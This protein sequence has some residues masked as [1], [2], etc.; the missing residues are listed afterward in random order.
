VLAP[1]LRPEI[2]PAAVALGLLVASQA[3][4]LA[5][6]F[7][8]KYAIDSGISRGRSGPLD[9]AAIAMLAAAVGVV[10]MKRSSILLAGRA[11]Q[12]ALRRLRERVFRHATSLDLSF[13]ERER[14]GVIVSRLTADLQAVEMLVVDTMVWAGSLVVYLLGSV[15]VLLV[16][17]VPMGTLSLL[18]IGPL[19]FALSAWFRTRSEKAYTRIRRATASVLTVMQ[20]SLRGFDVIQLFARQRR[21]VSDFARRNGEWRDA[22]G[23][24]IRLS[25]VYFPW[26]DIVR[27]AATLLVLG[28]GGWR[29]FQGVITVGLLAAFMLHLQ[30]T[31]EPIQALS[32]IYDQFQAAMAGLSRVAELL[33]ETANVVDAPGASGLDEA[34]GDL[35]LHTVAFRY[36]PDAP[37]AL[38]DVDLRAHAGR[39]IALVGETGA[40][41]STI[42]KL[43]LRF[44]D[45]TS[46][47]VSLDGR[48]LRE[49]SSSSRQRHSALVPQEGYLFAGGVRENIRFGRPGASDAEIESLC[50]AIGVDEA[51]R[52]LPAGYDT[53]VASL[54]GGERQM[55]ALARAL[56]ADPRVL[57]LDEATSA[58]DPGTEAKIQRAL[59]HAFRDR[60]TVLI[61]HRLSTV[62]RADVIAVVHHGRIVELGS[63]SELVA[64]PEGVYASLFTHWLVSA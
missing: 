48:D 4:A 25:G 46:G 22:N 47:V 12:N 14:T 10:A 63:H 35:A 56:V 43:L 5:S 17:D 53:D 11:G 44:Y 2:R 37:V 15:V 30:T 19:V 20:E 34:R 60:T 27:L 58:L 18:F 33:A 31:T 23:E 59:E 16:L 57:V 62:M 38:D 36:T 24:S 49:V 8:L 54:S 64:R 39:V 61:A 45:P 42:A 1:V 32:Q 3:A 51:L 7:L 50:G 55:I 9:R 6:P 13:F 29:V 26:V 52:A 40:G 21:N 41:K 28:L